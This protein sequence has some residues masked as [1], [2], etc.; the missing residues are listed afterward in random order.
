MSQ[1]S[2]TMIDLGDDIKLEVIRERD[3]PLIGRK[4][5]TGYLHHHAKGTPQRYEV[6]RRIAEIF[7]VP[8]EVVYVRSIQTEFG[9]GRSKIEIH[10]YRDPKRAEEIEPLH[11]RLKNLPPE[12]RKAK[13]QELRKAKESRK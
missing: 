7:K 4:E 9:W 13:L 6:R 11:I 2:S 5:I 10:I 3:N 1:Q 12:E 8:L